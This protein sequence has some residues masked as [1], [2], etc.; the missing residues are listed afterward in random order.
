MRAR[1]ERHRWTAHTERP[2]R[3]LQTFVRVYAQR[4]MDPADSLVIEPCPARLEQVLQFDFGEMVSCLRAGKYRASFPSV[5]IG[6]SAQPSSI[7]LP[8]GTTS[9]AVYFHPTGFSRLFDI[10]ATEISHEFYNARDVV[11][12]LLGSLYDQLAERRSF[13]ERVLLMEDFLVRRAA[14]VTP[15]TPIEEVAVY[16]FAAQGSIP[17]IDLARHSGLGLRQFERR[18]LQHTGVR[19]KLYSRIARFQSALD[20]KIGSPRRTWLDIAHSHGYHDQMH[21]VRD[22]HGLAGDVPGEILAS[23]GDMRPTCFKGF[24]ED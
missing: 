5:V 22:F 7:H 14:L 6:A 19:P 23:I 10:P 18:F 8:G 4:E 9:F 16:A 17:I 24:A 21:M 11:G 1:A 3:E 2:R 15:L 20:D 13:T 12:C